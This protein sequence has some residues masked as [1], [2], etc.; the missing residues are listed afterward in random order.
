MRER[1]GAALEERLEADPENENLERQSTL[2]HHAKITTI[3][4]FCLRLLREHF[5]ELDMDPGFRIAD[6]GELLLLQADVMKELLEEY[7]G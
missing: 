1:I 6:E 4:S 2:I 3:D 5:N 7:Y